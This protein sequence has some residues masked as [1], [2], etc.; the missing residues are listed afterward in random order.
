MTKSEKKDIAWINTLKGICILLVVLYHTVLPGFQS[1]VKDLAA[2]EW[3]AEMWV[4]FNTLLS[5]LRM[6]A[7]FFVSGLL[8]RNAIITRPWKQIATR[9]ITNLFYLYLLWGTIQWWCIVGISTEITGQRISQNLNAAYSG[10]FTEFLT[11]TFLAMSGSWYLYGLGLYFLCAKLFQRYKMPL[12]IAAAVLNYLAVEKIIPYWG[13]QSLA[14]Y[15]VFFM[16]GTFWCSQMLRLSEWRRE[17]GLL[18]LLLLL[19][20]GLHALFDLDK[21]LFLCVIAILVS[22]AACRLL[23]QVSN[24][25]LLN[26]MGRHTLPI[27]VIHRIFIEYFGMTAIL[28][29]QRHQLFE[30][31]WFS[32]LWACLYPLAIVALCSLCSVVV[33]SLINRG[34]GRALF[35]FPTL[36]K[37]PVRPAT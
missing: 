26:W 2:G 3:V 1:Q 34:I 25:A 15:F 5:P 7:F 35:I 4:Q 33:W 12:L 17:N 20:A 11:L 13:P 24:V 32:W 29:A 14:Q 37:R 9:R 23:S 21:N 28:F 6:P 36:I 10:T 18:W 27:Y 31:A 22:I 16:L 8:A 19:T 30:Q